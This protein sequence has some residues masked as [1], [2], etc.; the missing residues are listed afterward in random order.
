[1]FQGVCMFWVHL[2]LFFLQFPSIL[3]QNGGFKSCSSTERR[4]SARDLLVPPGRAA[5]ILVHTSVQ[6]ERAC[7]PGRAGC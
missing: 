2:W 5:F 3:Q 1:M 4:R 6:G 7:A